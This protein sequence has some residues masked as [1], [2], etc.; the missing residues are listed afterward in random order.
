M[1]YGIKSI[2]K[3]ANVIGDVAAN[4][5][6]PQYIKDLVKVAVEKIPDPKSSPTSWPASDSVRV[7]AQG[8]DGGNH[9]ITIEPFNEAFAPPTPQ[10]TA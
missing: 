7:E 1:S 10:A 3:K 2:G 8:H 6:V 9:T 5:Y 4:Q